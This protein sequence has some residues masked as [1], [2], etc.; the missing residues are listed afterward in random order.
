MEGRI[1]KVV[2]VNFSTLMNPKLQKYFLIGILFLSLNIYGQSGI[3]IQCDDSLWN[4]VYHSY[5]LKILEKCKLVT[6]IV[7]G[8]RFEADGDAHILIKLDTLQE[9][10]LY[11]MNYEKQ[12]GNLVAEP[13]CATLINEKNPKTECDGYVN[14]V[15]LPQLGEHVEIIGTY[16]LDTKHSWSEIH[17]V[18]SIK[19]IK[20]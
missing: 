3:K 17:P 18:T 1:V 11:P 14:N 2:F 9:N 8:A 16:V 6:G 19:L 15:Y 13:V 12:G 10:L 7:V 20:K 5:R 4:Q